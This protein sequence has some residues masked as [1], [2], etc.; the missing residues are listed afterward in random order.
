M[1]EQSER[2]EKTL[3]ELEAI[4]ESLESDELQLDEALGLFEQGIQRLRSAAEKLDAAHGRV[5]ELIQDVDGQ[6]DV[7]G[8]DLT[9]TEDS[10]PEGA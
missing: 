3:E 10:E 8:L 5:E 6:V 2:F 7:V 4:V 9:E 1:T